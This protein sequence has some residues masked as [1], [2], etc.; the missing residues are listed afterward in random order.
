MELRWLTT[1]PVADE[2]LSSYLSR[3]AR[4]H[5]MRPTTFAAFHLGSQQVWSRDLDR[6]ASPVLMQTIAD[7]AGLPL[8]RIQTMTMQAWEAQLHPAGHRA[9][10][11]AGIGPWITAA[12]IYHRTRRRYGLQY[13]S[14]C[15]GESPVFLKVWRLAFITMCPRHRVPLADACPRCDMPVM[16][17]RQQIS[18]RHCHA[19]ATDLTRARSSSRAEHRLTAVTL[20]HQGAFLQALGGG[21]IALGD[22][23]LDGSTYAHGMQV[24]LSRLRLFTERHR[25]RNGRQRSLPFELQRHPQRVATLRALGNLVSAWPASFSDAA[26]H[27]GVTRRAFVTTRPLPAWLRA[28]VALLPEGICQDRGRGPR[29]LRRRLRQLHRRRQPGWRTE[30]ARLLLRAAGCRP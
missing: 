5:G 13:C 15:L 7:L 12:G 27:Q 21:G 19:C 20:E 24:L 14:R 18:A 9:G 11:R 30:R 6:S 16:P 17:H 22:E 4:I 10:G 25:I 3:C 29:Q 1:P 28:G 2:L 26:Q 23:S 8:A